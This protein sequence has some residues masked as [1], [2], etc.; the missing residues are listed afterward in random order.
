[1]PYARF[2]DRYDDHRKIKRALRREPAAVAIHAMAITYCNRHNTNGELELDTVEEWLALL[3]YK[4]R[5]RRRVLDVLLSE[6]LF[7]QV[8]SETFLVEGSL[9]PERLPLPRRLRSA[10]I[11]RDGLVCGLCGAPVP[12]KD[13]HVDHVLPVSLG[14]AHELSNLQVTHSK[15]NLRKGARLLDA[16]SQV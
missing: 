13:V 9:C 5:R 8:D 12:Y 15:C 4:T 7:T 2:D 10:V 11:A 3:P 16:G 6:E 14:G 1:M